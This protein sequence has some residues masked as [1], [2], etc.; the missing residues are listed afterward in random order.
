[1]TAAEPL[2]ASASR[3]GF[4]GSAALLTASAWCAPAMAATGGEEQFPQLSALADG[5]VQ[6][7]KVAGMLIAVGRGAG[8]PQAI[9]RGGESLGDPVPLTIDSLFRI[10]SMTKPITGMTAMTLVDEG[11]LKL[12][13]PITEFLPR[14]ARMQVQATPDGSLTDVR[15]ATTAITVRHLLT[16]TAG[17][18]YSVI[19]NG[20]L[21]DALITR[22]LVGGRLSRTPVPGIP[23][24]VPAP[25]LAVFADRLAEL[26]L[27]YEPGTQWSYSLGIDL[28]GRVIEVASGQPFDAVV[29][30]RILAPAGMT[31]TWFRVPQAQAHRLTTNYLAFGGALTAVDPGQSSVYLDEP[32]YPMGGTGLVSSP[33]D[34]DRFLAMLAGGG[35]IGGRRVMSAA[36]VRLGTSNLLPAGAAITGTRIA[37]TGFGAGGQVGIGGPGTFGWTGAAGTIAAVDLA[38][39]LREALFTQYMPALAYPL[40]KE[41]WAAAALD[42]GR[43]RT[44]APVGA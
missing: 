6:E 8:P 27:V 35:R 39:H 31:S 19:Q 21:R 23:M 42:L 17:L 4:L 12:D 20:P 43:P 7:R 5:Y 16:H 24:G 26:P 10:Y 22:G 33:R 37:G 30:D 9:A 41:F 25:S 13:Q 18:G 1:M 34:Y 29:R 36:A 28:L 40:Q 44:G 11:K 15:P 32:P 14:F 38:R 2:G 3:R